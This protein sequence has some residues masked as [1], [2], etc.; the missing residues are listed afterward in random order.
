MREYSTLYDTQMKY[1]DG[2]PCRVYSCYDDLTVDVHVKW[3][4]EYGLSGLFLQRHEKHMDDDNMREWKDW[5]TQA[6]KRA[7]FKYDV[8]FCMM[9]CNNDKQGRGHIMVENVINDWMHLVDDLNITQSP[10]Y[11]YQNGKP[12]IGFWGLGFENYPMTPEE[13]TEILDFFQD[14]PEERYRVY[15]MGGVPHNW[16]TNPKAGW[17]PVFDRL[18]MISPWRTIFADPYDPQ[19]IGRMI[20]DLSYCDQLG[21]DYNPVISPGASA[22]HMRS[23]PNLRNWKPRDGGNFIWQQ[24]YEVCR[25]GSKFL[26][27]AMFDEIDEGT[28]MYKLSRT[29]DD[30][31]V[32]ADQV[33]LD[34][35]GYNLP[36]DWYLRVG[37]EIQKMFDGTIPLT[38]QL[39]LTPRHPFP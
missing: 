3:I 23:D 38:Q 33:P 21:I 29:A 11:M 4:K 14:A 26:Y 35:D 27:M 9:P 22:S 36:E 15:V 13:A 2:S 5:V 10:Q 39:P 31:P 8:K 34:I 37:R 32:G 28:A 7:C 1:R 24:A 19:V 25:R 30:C 17:P 6:V 20:G 16:R 12:V 18:D